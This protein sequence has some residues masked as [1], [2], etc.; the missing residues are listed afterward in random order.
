M[1]ADVWSAIVELELGLEKPVVI[2]LSMGGG[3]AQSLAIRHPNHI[4]GLVL[5]STSSEFPDATR[6]RFI[7]RA[8]RAEREGMAAV[9]DDT[10]PR[11]FTTEFTSRHPEEVELTRRTVLATD[12]LAFAAASRANAAR[13]LTADLRQIACPVLFIG[14]AEDPADPMRAV[15]IFRRELPQL[16]WE[17]IPDVSHLVPVE[18]P[19]AFNTILLRFLSEIACTPTAD[20]GERT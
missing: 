2:G 3:V 15:Q 18:A 11:W 4:G 16:R 5:V 9:V 13:N 12:P 10:V 6:A 14:G 1:A 8:A 19:S 17:I 7:G 20:E